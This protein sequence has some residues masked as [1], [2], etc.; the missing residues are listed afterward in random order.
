MVGQPTD[1][2]SKDRQNAIEVASQCVGQAFQY[3]SENLDAVGLPLSPRLAESL[4]KKLKGCEAEVAR[5]LDDQ[6]S[7]I[8][9]DWEYG[10]N[11]E[12]APL[13]DR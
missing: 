5:L 7:S 6:W 4:R 9:L 3:A 2:G 11:D 13:D 1:S 8:V 10:Q 12:D